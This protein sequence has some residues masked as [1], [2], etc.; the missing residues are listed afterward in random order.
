[1]PHPVFADDGSHPSLGNGRPPPGRTAPVSRWLVEVEMDV[2]SPRLE[3][4]ASADKDGLPMARQALRAL[5]QSVGADFDALHD[6]EL[7]VSEACSNAIRH[8][9]DN[10]SGAIGVAIEVRGGSIRAVVRDHGRGMP[11]EPPR[12]RDV[13]GLGLRLIDAIADDL[14]IRSARGLGTEVSMDLPVASSP[15]P[16]GAG[17]AIERVVRRLVAIAA[18][19]SDM[20]P[21]R[22]TEALMAAEIAAREA[23]KRI[24]EGA[25][26]LRIERDADGVKMLLGP[27]VPG[28]AEAILDVSE[29]PTLG[30]ILE[31][32]ADEVWKVP[33]ET[34]R[35]SDGEELAL[36]FAA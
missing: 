12:A 16:L 4:R 31:R 25:V 21:A 11:T 19:Q 33:P 10:A 13:G 36:R 23:P 30:S 1:M 27:L 35:P 8:A 20:P 9:Y 18:A 15:S 32:L 22:I 3:L 26:R 24:V 34:G 29:V 6:A 2:E 14:A 28:G 17:T 7:A 5:G